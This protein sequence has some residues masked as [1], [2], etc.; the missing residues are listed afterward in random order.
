MNLD[1]LVIFKL[2]ARVERELHVEVPLME[3]ALGPSVSEF[4]RLLLNQIEEH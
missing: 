1:S 4:S 2:A 3:L